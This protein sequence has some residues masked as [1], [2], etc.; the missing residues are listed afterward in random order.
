MQALPT[1]LKPFLFFPSFP[2]T[3]HSKTSVPEKQ[4]FQE[5]TGCDEEEPSVG[6]GRME[7]ALPVKCK[8]TSRNGC[9]LAGSTLRSTACVHADFPFGKGHLGKPGEGFYAN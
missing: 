2:P 1:G 8:Q 4:A 5:H 7:A 9:W 6:Y 3:A